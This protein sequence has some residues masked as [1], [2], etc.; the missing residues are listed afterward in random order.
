MW[1]LAQFLI[2]NH[3]GASRPS[4]CPRILAR[5]RQPA[6]PTRR[7][8]HFAKKKPPTPFSLGKQSTKVGTRP[9]GLRYWVSKRWETHP[10]LPDLHSAKNVQRFCSLA[11]CGSTTHFGLV[12]KILP[13]GSANFSA[14]PHQS[15]EAGCCSPSFP[16]RAGHLRTEILSSH[17]RFMLYWIANMWN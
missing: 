7:S 16:G 9:T 15:K 11:P 4:R 1:I 6:F 5:T 10:M 13:I 2:H 8:P 3:S 14:S 12:K 17:F